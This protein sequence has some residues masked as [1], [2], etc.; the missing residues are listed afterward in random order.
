MTIPFYFYSLRNNK[1]K[2]NHRSH[3]FVLDYSVFMH[4]FGV[5]SRSIGSKGIVVP[6]SALWGYLVFTIATVMPLSIYYCKFLK[7]K[8]LKIS[9]KSVLP[10]SPL[11]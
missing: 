11:H 3:V 8:E 7:L 10:V 1:G 4:P 5:V 6:R 2:V 9:R